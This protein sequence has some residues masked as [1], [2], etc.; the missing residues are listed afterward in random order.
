METFAQNIA[1]KIAAQ[2]DFD[3]N[4]KA[5]VAYGLTAILQM[6]T[7]LVIISVIGLIFGFWYE[8]IL[9][10]TGV[11]IIRKSTGGAHSQSM[12]GCIIIS[13]SSITVLSSL[14]RYLFGFQTVPLL[15]LL[16]SVLVYSICILIFYLRVPVD[17]PNKP[18]L[19][20]EKIKR[21]RRQSFIILTIFFILSAAVIFPAEQN[22]RFFSIGASIRLTLLWQMF[23]L[24]KTGGLIFGKID[25][26]IMLKAY[27]K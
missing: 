14:S 24:T 1:A 25:S 17:T 8:C 13:V 18:I 4:K 7:I 27:R 22:Q 12:F 20:Q 26:K 3:D 6:L 21:L 5:V 19:K 23:T 2:M 15:N 16:E 9:I 10:F 11:G